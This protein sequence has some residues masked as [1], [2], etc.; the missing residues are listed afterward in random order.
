MSIQVTEQ[1][2]TTD[3]IIPS[4]NFKIAWVSNDNTLTSRLYTTYLADKKMTCD[5]TATCGF[6]VHMWLG[7]LHVVTFTYIPH[8]GILV[9]K[10]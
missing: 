10:L 7:Y 6:N 4:S 8:I 3:N 5:C 9:S 2:E 1:T